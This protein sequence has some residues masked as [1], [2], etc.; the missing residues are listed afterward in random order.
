MEYETTIGLEVHAQ[1]LTGS[2]M[3]CG[4]DAHY[5]GAAP[6]SHVCPTCLGLPGAL[7]VINGR[8]V[9]FAAMT[10]LALHCRIEHDNFMARKNYFYPDLP[11]GYQRSQY[12]D[13][14]CVGGWLEIMGDDGQ[15]KRVG[16]TRV[17]IEEDTG[18]LL[19]G[20]SGHSLIDF[21]RA[22]VPLMEIVSEPD[23]ASP[24]EAKRYFQKLRQI[25][26]WVGVNS[27]N[28]EEG[29]LRCDA[30]VSVRPMGQKEYGTKIEIK[31]LNS[32]RNVERALIYEIK[33]QIDEL[34]AG[35]SLRQE[36]RGW[37][38]ARG[39]TVGQRSKEFAH[40]YRYFPD[41]DLP[42]LALDEAWVAARQAELPELPD[43]R[44]ERFVASYQLGYDTADLLTAERGVADYFEQ[45][46]AQANGA[47]AREVANWTVGELFRLLN[48]GG[49]TLE[50]AATRFPPAY[51]GAVIQLVNDGTI[52]RT[53]AKQVFETS[54]RSGDAPLA[55]VE[56][57][58][59]KVIGDSDALATLAREVIAANEKV[60]ADYRKGKT[61][62]IKALV[63]QI[64][65]AT[66]GQ[67]NPQ[68]ALA[69]L[70][71]ELNQ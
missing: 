39:V 18:K 22:G 25:L 68:A 41:P 14:I 47:P 20:D 50:Q 60:V 54:Y 33:R 12:D 51:I 69:A 67:A 52:T 5:S 21:N 4:C 59:L 36:T 61:A 64:M 55:V 42:P 44:R 66:K 38:E 53:L 3:F 57:Q 58:G 6:N 48:D 34:R 63:G 27:G 30:N 17:H 7:P 45:A 10:G 56:A 11:S 9:E 49:E 40:D 32:F 15:P 8:A 16:I 62:A 46:V 35:H 31:N 24:E 19:H 37:D 1:I 29:A 71:A 23:I 65:K 70:E 28:M 26:L 2:K 43:A 13:P